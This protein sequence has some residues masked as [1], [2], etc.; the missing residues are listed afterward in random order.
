MNNGDNNVPVGNGCGYTTLG[1]YNSG[2]GAGAMAPV[3]AS[4][5]AGGN[6]VVV[7]AFGGIAYDTL[8]HGQKGNRSCNGYFNV[9]G[10][11][12]NAN[13][14]CTQYMNRNCS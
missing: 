7:P 14:S 13:G 10:A 4:A 9:Q 12:P 5:V 6:L 2:A 11:Y 3:P 8:N 1:S